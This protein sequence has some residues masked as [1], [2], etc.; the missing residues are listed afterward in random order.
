MAWT[1]SSV[2]FTSVFASSSQTPKHNEALGGEGSAEWFNRT[3]L[4]DDY[5]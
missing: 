4:Y 1:Q 3:L 2:V 5:F